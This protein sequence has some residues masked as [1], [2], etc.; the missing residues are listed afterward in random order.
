MQNNISEVIYPTPLIN[1]FSFIKIFIFYTCI[2]FV[3]TVNH[4][5]RSLLFQIN[6]ILVSSFT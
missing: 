5:F 3:S 1:T 6:Q 4:S 2:A